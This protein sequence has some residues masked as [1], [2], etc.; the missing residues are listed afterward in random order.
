M[1]EAQTHEA[2]D[3]RHDDEEL[4]HDLLGKDGTNNGHVDHEVGEHT[5]NQQACRVLL[6]L[7]HG[8]G[9]NEVGRVDMAQL[10]RHAHCRCEESRTDE[11]EERGHDEQPQALAPANL[12][13]DG[14]VDHIHHAAGSQF[15]AQDNDGKKA[16]AEVQSE[17]RS[18]EALCMLFDGLPQNRGNAVPMAR[19]TPTRIERTAKRPKDASRS[20]T[21]LFTAAAAV[22][23]RDMFF[24]KNYSGRAIQLKFP[25]DT[26]TSTVLSL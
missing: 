23:L 25:H 11:V 6:Q 1:L 21:F 3:N 22:S 9:G 5:F 12:L 16:E 13:I 4:G 15:G 14:A 2:G 18:S 26:H 8:Q 19:Y 20:V 7:A 10:R 24:K 17:D